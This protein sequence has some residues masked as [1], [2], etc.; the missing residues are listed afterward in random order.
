MHEFF[1]LMQAYKKQRH[2]EEMTAFF[3]C[4]RKRIHLKGLELTRVFSHV[5]KKLRLYLLVHS[6]GRTSLGS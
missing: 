6:P 4:Q 1:L 3:K 5:E 2:N